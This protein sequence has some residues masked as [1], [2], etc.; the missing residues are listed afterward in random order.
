MAVDFT[1]KWELESS[2]NIDNYLKALGKPDQMSAMFTEIKIKNL[3]P[4]GIRL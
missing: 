3:G 1:G 2:E 4:N